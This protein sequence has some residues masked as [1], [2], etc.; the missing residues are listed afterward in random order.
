MVKVYFKLILLS[1]FNRR[2]LYKVLIIF[3]IGFISRWFV[4]SFFDIN[5]FL[6]FYSY[7]SLIYYFLFSCFVIFVHN[8]IDL[9]YLVPVVMDIIHSDSLT[10]NSISNTI[11][12]APLNVKGLSCPSGNTSV[13]EIKSVMMKNGVAVG[14]GVNKD[15]IPTEVADKH[16][17]VSKGKVNNLRGLNDSSHGSSHESSL[18]CKNNVTQAKSGPASELSTKPVITDS[19]DLTGSQRAQ[20]KANIPVV[21]KCVGNVVGNEVLG[22]IGINPKDPKVK[23]KI[24]RK[25]KDVS[26]SSKA[27]I[28]FISTELKKSVKK[29]LNSTVEKLKLQKRTLLWFL[30]G[31]R[32]K[33]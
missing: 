10:V 11:P 26:I 2:T 8:L 6:D 27:K 17:L 4:N 14:T 9:F 16:K 20:N 13:S 18:G 19:S 12:N 24:F 5:V 23:F 33:K 3:T 25:F 22:D 7:I 15:L 28:I 30:R 1:V 31:G 21:E 29:D 32:D